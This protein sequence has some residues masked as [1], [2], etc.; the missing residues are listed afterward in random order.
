[1][2]AAVAGAVVAAVAP[3]GLCSGDVFAAVPASDPALAPSFSVDVDEGPFTLAMM[4]GIPKTEKKKPLMDIYRQTILEVVNHKVN[5]QEL[6]LPCACLQ[7]HF[8]AYTKT[9]KNKFAS[10]RKNA[11]MPEL[12][13]T[14]QF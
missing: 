8:T 10:L 4:S 1:M 14:A 6:I 5:M 7:P 9:Y 2:S 3:S 11:L 13:S 12:P